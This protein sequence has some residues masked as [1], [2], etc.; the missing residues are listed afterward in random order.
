MLWCDVNVVATESQNTGLGTAI[1]ELLKK[2][3]VGKG[4][5]KVGFATSVDYAGTRNEL[6]KSDTGLAMNPRY[7]RT[8]AHKFYTRK[9]GRSS[10]LEVEFG[11]EDWTRLA[12]G[13]AGVI[14]SLPI[15][16]AHELYSNGP[17]TRVILSPNHVE[18][19]DQATAGIKI[20]QIF[21][22]YGASKEI[23]FQLERDPAMKPWYDA[24]RTIMTAVGKGGDA[25]HAVWYAPVTETSATGK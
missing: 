1:L 5:D 6:E 14:G 11:R 12:L 15:S 20:R 21:K 7:G 22:R 23:V 24:L 8:P 2:E 13:N 16:T 4:A 25:P 19:D 17:V 3:A 18:G 9:I 10:Y